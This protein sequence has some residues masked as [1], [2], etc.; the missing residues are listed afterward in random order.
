MFNDTLYCELMAVAATVVFLTPSPWH[1]CQGSSGWS[2]SHP[3]RT[4][5]WGGKG[6]VTQQASYLTRCAHIGDPNPPGRW[7]KGLAVM[8]PCPSVAE[9]GPS[10]DGFGFLQEL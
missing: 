7:Q 2:I 4:F 10:E 5:P 3:A 9:R 1:L 6:L 8:T